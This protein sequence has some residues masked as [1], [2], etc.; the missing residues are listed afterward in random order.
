MPPLDLVC[1]LK[2]I[3]VSNSG[4]TS[5]SLNSNIA[6]LRK[7]CSKI[8]WCRYTYTHKILTD[9][10]I[11]CIIFYAKALVAVPNCNLSVNRE[12]A[13]RE[14]A[15]PVGWKYLARYEHGDLEPTSLILKFEMTNKYLKSSNKAN[16]CGRNNTGF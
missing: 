6:Y 8:L 15:A 3:K 14:R 10:P 9:T 12:A 13:S 2:V 4:I 11:Y 5:C 16:K 1:T 7:P